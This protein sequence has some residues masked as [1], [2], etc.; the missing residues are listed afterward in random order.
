MSEGQQD[1][2]KK[3]ALLDKLYYTIGRQNY[4]FLLAGTFEKN[5]KKGFTKWKKYSECVFPIDFDGKCT[6]WKKEK[7]FEQINQR[8]VLPNEL[9]LDIEEKNKIA[10]IVK[11]L[12]KSKHIEEF[13]IYDT[14]SRGYHIHLFFKEKVEEDEKKFL[15]N[16]FEADIQKASEKTLIALE[17]CPHWKT[18]ILKKEVTVKE[19]LNGE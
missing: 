15:I 14:G 8:Q 17:D 12:A 10:P 16:Y 18:G 5:G 13:H 11:V 2:Q 7:F 1:L 9:V 19:V 3:K 4:D 6:D